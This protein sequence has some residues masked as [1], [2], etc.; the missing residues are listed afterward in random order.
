VL[1][2]FDRFKAVNDTYGHLAGDAVL[3][4]AAQ[5][6]LGTLRPYDAIGRYGGEEFLVILPGCDDDA[7]RK[8]AERMRS[9]VMDRPMEI[10]GGGT[11]HQ[12]ASFGG[13]VAEP[14]SYTSTESLIK[15]ADEA[16]YRAK[17][18]GRN[19]VVFCLS[20]PQEEKE[21]D[22]DLRAVRR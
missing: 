20:S 1:V 11:V 13:T 18:R 3:R 7:T 5:R 16:L 14:G 12:T 17:A 6:L 19:H 22:P 8:H 4:E 9:G 2:D 10:P 21:E 15:A